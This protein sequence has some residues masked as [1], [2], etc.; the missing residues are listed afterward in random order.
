MMK[1]QKVAFAIDTESCS[2]FENY[3]QLR[4]DVTFIRNYNY[5]LYISKIEDH[6]VF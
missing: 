4:T 1:I 6:I 2:N 3:E 5:G